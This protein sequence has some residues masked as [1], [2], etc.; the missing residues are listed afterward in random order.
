MSLKLQSVR[1]RNF[2]RFT[3]FRDAFLPSHRLS[4][5]AGKSKATAKWK[6]LEKNSGRKLDR[7][8]CCV[9][10]LHREDMASNGFFALDVQELR[11][12]S[13]FHSITVKWSDKIRDVKLRLQTV[14]GYPASRMHLLRSASSPQL[15]NKKTLG[16]LGIDKPGH[17]LI[18]SLQFSCNPQHVVEPYPGIPLDAACKE[19]VNTVQAGLNASQRPLKTDLLDCTGGVYFLKDARGV[20]AAVFKPQDEEQ[21]MPSNP[22][23]HAGNG[24]VGL[25][26]YFKP[27]E[28]F[29]REL[30]AYQL[31]EGGMC[32]VPP[33][34]VAHVEHPSFSYVKTQGLA[35]FPKLGSLQGYVRGESF[36]DI[37]P[38]LVSPFE[39]RYAYIVCIW[40]AP[41]PA[42]WY[43]HACIK[44]I[45]TSDPP[46]ST[47]LS[48][49][50]RRLRCWTCA[51]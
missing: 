27:G 21:G 19:M 2:V 7:L 46:S 31:D 34:C 44:W 4:G 33:T 18:L 23:G 49:R 42:C 26:P 13:T 11:K 24:L 43:Y 5:W 37:S 29:T 50:C 1:Y 17:L 36:E 20:L 30:A 41:T 32:G 35:T 48:N 40:L 16:E 9:A 45:A 38:S 28:G 10:S 8:N 22:K 14:T 51:Y 3:R 25:R 47:S 12:P 15:S 6:K 39:V